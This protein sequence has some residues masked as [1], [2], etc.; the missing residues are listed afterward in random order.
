MPEATLG[1]ASGGFGLRVRGRG[2]VLLIMPREPCL[3]HFEIGVL[4][5]DEDRAEDAPVS[6]AALIFDAYILV[7]DE[8]RKVFTRDIAERLPLLRR[9]DSL[10]TDF[11][12]RFGR[13]K[14]SDSVSICDLY[15][16]TFNQVTKARRE[17]Q[18]TSKYS[19]KFLLQNVDLL[20]RRKNYNIID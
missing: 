3:E 10:E 7:R 14:D 5:I 20:E 1:C 19:Y 17:T 8:R 16:S 9:V 6:V 11:V 12:L 2:V 4:A 15:D 18:N 13:V